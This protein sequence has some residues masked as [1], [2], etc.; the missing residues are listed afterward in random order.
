MRQNP[1]RRTALLDAAI[2]V[3]AEQGSRGLTFRAID[4]EAKVPNGTASNYFANRDVLLMQVA[5]RTNERLGPDT[6]ELAAT[7]QAP[8]SLELYVQL[9]REIHGRLHTDRNA[10]LALMELRLEAIRRPELHATLTEFFIENMKGAVRNHLDEGMPG[11]ELTVV[12]IFLAMTGLEIET[13]TFP[14]VLAPYDLDELITAMVTRL[15]P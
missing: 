8:R 12:L 3:L 5:V 1:E 15:Q 10:Y 14:E 2:D 7:M 13:L 9:M 4:I 11:D 6:E